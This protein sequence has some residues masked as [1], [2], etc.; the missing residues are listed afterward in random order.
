VAAFSFLRGIRSRIAETRQ[1]DGMIQIIQIRPARLISSLSSG[2][3]LAAMM[4][5]L[6]S[7]IPV[8]ASPF[9]PSPG[10]SPGMNSSFQPALPTTISSVYLPL[11]LRPA[12]LEITFLPPYGSVL[13]LQGRV[14]CTGVTP[15]THHIAVYIR[16][17]GGWWTKPYFIVP[18]TT[19]R[20]D[21][22]WTTDITTGGSD[23]LAI[24]IAAFLVP[25]AYTPPPMS[26]GAVL[27]QELFSNSTTYTLVTR[28]ATRTI[29]F[30]GHTWEVKF[31]PTPA[32]PGP[33]FFSDDPA[34]VWVDG[35][36]YLHLN[37]I[38]RNGTWY[39]SEVICTDTLQYGTYTVTLGSRVDLLDK[40]VV[41]GFFSWDTDAPQFNYREIDIEFSRWG[42][43]G[44]LNA[45][46]VLQPWDVSGNRHRFSMNLP[47]TDSVHRF[48]WSPDLIQFDS[49]DG[50]GM[51]LQSWT[52]TNTTYI[53]PAGAGNA[54]INLWLFN[55]LPPSD[56]QNAEVIIKSFQFLPA[57]P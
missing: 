4:A 43:N 42:E 47:G 14:N 26:G 51:P 54:R 36:G 30:S 23:P 57:A 1:E 6:V 40:N 32:G 2:L 55:G 12:C 28:R 10:N 39:S 33:N 41:L 7:N 8:L 9:L 25:N 27:P 50:S 34:D 38:N 13:D 24:D 20:S 44:G 11:L 48:D 16:V 35:N 49:W 15:D 18:L 29:Q 19:I 17:S 3:C 37:I 53:P 46:Y 45:Q 31:T 5:I 52:Y 56:S 22:S 21:G